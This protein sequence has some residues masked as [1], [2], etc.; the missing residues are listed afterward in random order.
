MKAAVVVVTAGMALGVAGCTT[1]QG[2]IVGGATGA[3][4]GGAATGTFGGAV[5]GGAI[6]ALA[7]AIL[8]QET[9]GV[10]TYR[11]KGRLYR[12]RCRRRY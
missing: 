7:G 2:A 6:G 12:E 10:C 9:N 3:V 5:V 1:Q 8:V 11:Y 4:V